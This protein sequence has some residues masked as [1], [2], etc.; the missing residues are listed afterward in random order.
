VL[1]KSAKEIPDARVSLE[2]GASPKGS[3]GAKTSPPEINPA[4]LFVHIKDLE[5][6]NK[7]KKA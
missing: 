2:V 4:G 6:F 1:A 7:V 3:R 5:Q